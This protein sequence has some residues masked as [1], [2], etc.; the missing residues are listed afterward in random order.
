[1]LG[2]VALESWE[3]SSPSVE[4][5]KMSVSVTVWRFQHTQSAGVCNI[6]NSDTMFLRKGVKTDLNKGKGR[7]LDIA[8]WL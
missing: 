6:Y 7:V 1:M 3:F 8:Y 2:E 5:R 4:Q